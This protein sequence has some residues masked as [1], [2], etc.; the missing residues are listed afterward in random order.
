MERE[1]EAEEMQRRKARKNSWFKSAGERTS[2]DTSAVP[3]KGVMAQVSASVRF[4]TPDILLQRVRSDDSHVPPHLRTQMDHELNSSPTGSVKDLDHLVETGQIS[5]NVPRRKNLSD[6]VGRTLRIFTFP[7]F[8]HESAIRQTCYD[9]YVSKVWYRIFLLASFIHILS[10]ALRPEVES[11]ISLLEV[12]S[13]E[14]KVALQVLDSVDIAC[15]AIFALEIISGIVACG[16][17]FGS[18]AWMWK[19]HTNKMELLILLSIAV[20]NLVLVSG[21]S[22]LKILP[23][24]LV[25]ILRILSL[26]KEYAPDTLGGG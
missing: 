19:S 21:S 20:E 13:I 26:L 5:E 11:G 18:G 10:I 16:F 8:S 6:E 15:I 23:F 24:R 2:E 7:G 12:L 1:E 3:P 9:M 14:P 17:V 25:R 22:V 4:I